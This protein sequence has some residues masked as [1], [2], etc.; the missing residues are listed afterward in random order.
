MCKLYKSIDDAIHEKARRV[1]VES[2]VTKCK[3]LLENRITKNDSLLGLAAKTKQPEKLQSELEEWLAVVNKRHD[4]YMENVRN[5]IVSN[6]ATEIQKR[7]LKD[8][9]NPCLLVP[10]RRLQLLAGKTL[11]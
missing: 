11:H 1:R 2:L 9:T 4:E 10:L 3:D 7:A 6:E 8:P 5:Y